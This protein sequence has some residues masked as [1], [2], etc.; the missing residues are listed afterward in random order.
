VY[1]SNEVAWITM[2]LDTR[3]SLEQFVLKKPLKWDFQPI[4]PER[5][6]PA[7]MAFCV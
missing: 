4:F 2:E 5:I 3:G 7:S 1:Q 6:G